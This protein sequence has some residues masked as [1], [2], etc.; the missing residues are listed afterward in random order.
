M[1]NVERYRDGGDEGDYPIVAGSVV[2]LKS[3]G[4][5]MTVA[6]VRGHVVRCSW[7]E[8]T[9]A[10]HSVFHLNTLHNEAEPPPF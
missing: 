6:E 10:R 7:F 1:S 4:P 3:G 9:T 2:T 5:R 8:G